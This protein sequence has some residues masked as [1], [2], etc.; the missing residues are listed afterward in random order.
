[1]QFNI[2]VHDLQLSFYIRTTERSGLPLFLGTPVGG[3]NNIHRTLTD[4]FI[5]IELDE[6]YV[7]LTASLGGEP[8]SVVNSEF[9]SDD[10]W[11]KIH[12]KR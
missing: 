1:M 4:D 6:G 3:S 8:Q 11:H 2:I 5:A 10:K 12:V 7:R 9:V